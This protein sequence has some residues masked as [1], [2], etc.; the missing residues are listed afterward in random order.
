[1]LIYGK[2][3]EMNVIKKTNYEKNETAVSP[4]IGVMLMLVV[5]LVIAAFVSMFAGNAFASAE[6]SPSTAINVKIISNGGAN[7]DQYVML[8]E[9]AGG[10]SIPSADLKIMT[11]YLASGTDKSMYRSENSSRTMTAYTADGKSI[12]IPIITDASKG[13]FGDSQ[14]NFGRYTFEPGTIISTYNSA[15]TTKIV[16]FDVTDKT[17]FGFDKGSKVTVN[18]VHIPTQTVLFNKDV[19]VE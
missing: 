10:D 19:V 6:A 16:G 18:I 3:N 14:L 7:H 15:G 4:V 9:N 8:I 5:T 13:N 12:I 2:V 1:M 17:K 11:Y